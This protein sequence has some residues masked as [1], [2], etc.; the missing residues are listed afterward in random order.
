MRLLRHSGERADRRWRA[1]VARMNFG[2]FSA[3][4]K[5]LRE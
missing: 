5:N 3:Q 2:E 4:Q 1:A